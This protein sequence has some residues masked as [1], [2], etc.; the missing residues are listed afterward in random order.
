[1]YPTSL[2]DKLM[3]CRGA[4]KIRKTC[5][6]FSGCDEEIEKATILVESVLIRIEVQMRFLRKI[7]ELLE[8]ELA[9]SQLNLLHVLKGRLEQ[10]ISELE[11][12]NSGTIKDY[13][14]R[15]KWAI[16]DK[17]HGLANELEAWQNR[18]D[19]T[20][21]LIILNSNQIL[22]SEIK[23][24]RKKLTTTSE[25]QCILPD[26]QIKPVT[27]LWSLRVASRSEHEKR[28]PVYLDPSSIKEPQGTPILFSVARIVLRQTSMGSMKRSIVEGITRPD[29]SYG[30]F[31][32][33]LIKKDVELLARK[34]QQVDPETFHLL[35]CRGVIERPGFEA[36]LELAY[37]M[38][39]TDVLPTSLRGILLDKSFVASLSSI[40]KLA[41][42][43][44]RSV[45]FVHAC[46]FVHKS[47]RPENILLFPS[48]HSLLGTS[49]LIGF[50]QFRH[51]EQQSEMLGDIC[52]HRNLY[53][54]PERQGATVHRRYIMQH[55]IYSLGVCL[56]EIGLWQSFV[57]YPGLN[58]N[59]VP[60]LPP[61]SELHISNQDFQLP[62][63]AEKL[64]TKGQLADMARRY[65]PSKMGDMYTEVVI[66]CLECLDKEKG[67]FSDGI[68][69]DKDGVIIGTRFI[70]HI[71]SRIDG[72]SL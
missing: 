5:K 35:K 67:K 11:V 3:R 56:L 68:Q 46:G 16:K 51:N 69:D 22:D 30:P 54:H 72:I 57:Q 4:K 14:R 53:R 29:G 40:V 62:H 64:C 18:F 65:L 66:T 71:V 48:E 9:Q 25:S 8:A 7:A 39:N 21:Y 13:L 50:S 10:T 19:P 61:S 34:L 26:N 55:D 70:Q 42:Q 33:H 43:L 1:L 58:P 60:V 38:P 63:L 17:L 49:Y 37:S 23:Q 27:N 12:P 32:T 59:S 15:W 41:K 47:I 31:D 45:S 24:L 2:T 44:V 52:W 6:N 36:P 20:W 28:L